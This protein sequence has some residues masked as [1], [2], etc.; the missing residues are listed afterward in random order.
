VQFAGAAPLLVG[1]QVNLQIPV[2]LPAGDYPVVITVNGIRS[3][4]AVISVGP[5][6]GK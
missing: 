3:N 2:D 6:L 1:D 5:A 4:S